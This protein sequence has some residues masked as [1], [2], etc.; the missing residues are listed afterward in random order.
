MAASAVLKNIVSIEEWMA[1]TKETKK[2]CTLKKLF[3]AIKH[4]NLQEKMF[5]GITSLVHSLFF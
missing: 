1:A 2:H 3:P 5:L 4:S